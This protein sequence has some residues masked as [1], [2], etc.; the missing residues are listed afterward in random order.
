MTSV[1]ALPFWLP[2]RQGSA[3]GIVRDEHTEALYAA[4][5]YV[6][7]VLLWTPVDYDNGLVGHCRACWTGSR[8]A[9]AF[10]QPTRHDCVACVGTGFE[11]GYRAR[12][13][14]PAIISDHTL[15][16]D[17]ASRGV[18]VTDDVT[19]ETTDDFTLHNGDYM[20]RADNTRWQCAEKS[21]VVLRSGFS[22]PATAAAIGGMIQHARLE[23]HGSIVYSVPP[24]TKASVAAV[25]AVAAQTHLPATVSPSEDV[26][27]PL[28]VTY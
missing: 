8:E 6:F 2:P 14:R 27:G 20:I 7:F 21:S 1:R 19:V 18:N 4:G 17:P 16:T 23:E 25:L 12:I 11:G 15:N 22:F 9:A 5:E 24:L 13:V 3:E 26:R 10:S 28:E